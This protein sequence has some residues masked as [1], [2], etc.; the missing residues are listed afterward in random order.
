MVTFSGDGGEA[1]LPCDGTQNGFYAQGVY[2][3]MPRWRV[4]L[5][6]DRLWSDNKLQVAGN[7]SGEAYVDLLDEFALLGGYDPWRWALMADY[8]HSEFSR[9]RLQYARDH[10]RPG[11]ADNQFL[12]QY[13]MTMGAHGAH[14]Y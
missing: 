14:K 6:Y 4:G 5:R 3:F 7:T 11:D 13:I 10:S 1:L 8:S 2:Q 9:V 12:L